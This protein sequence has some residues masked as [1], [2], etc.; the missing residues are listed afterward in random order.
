MYKTVEERI[1]KEGLLPVVV[2]ENPADGIPL[3][4]T[5]KKA[6]IHAIEITLR[7]KGA[8]EAIKAIADHCS[9]ILVGAGTVLNIKQAKEAIACG[10]KF[11][12]SPGFDTSLVNWC[13][14]N[15]VAVFPGCVT[16]GELMMAYNMGL[17]I[18]KFFPANL[19][20]G[21]K[22]LTTLATVFTDMRFMPTGGITIENIKDYIEKDFVSAVGGSWIC[23]K[24]DINGHRWER[25]EILAREA[26]N[27]LKYS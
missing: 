2:I 21:I 19:Y 6:N 16:P 1:E 5:L 10:A 24:E 20:G 4:E 7:T 27:V 9:D 3:A 12:V 25:I 18:V 15:D 23:K 8:L 13:I 26:K 22:G 11:I 17:R 14:E